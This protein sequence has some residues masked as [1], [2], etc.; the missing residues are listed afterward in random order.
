MTPVLG[1]A[2][3]LDFLHDDLVERLVLSLRGPDVANGLI[4]DKDLPISKVSRTV[5]V[6]RSASKVSPVSDARGKQRLTP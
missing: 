4:G 6:Q 1:E 5:K 3:I 2:F